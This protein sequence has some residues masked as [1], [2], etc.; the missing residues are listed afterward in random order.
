MTLGHTL[1]AIAVVM[2]TVGCAPPGPKLSALQTEALRQTMYVGPPV[3]ANISYLRAGDAKGTRV[4]LVH[5]TPGSALGWTD[6]LLDP[7]PGI[8]I[9]ALDRPGFGRS[10]PEHAVTNLAAQAAAVAALLPTDG[11]SVVL[12]GHSLG[13]AVVTRV[14]ADHPARVLALVLLATSLDPAQE[15]IHPAQ[16]V[17]QIW[18]LRVLLPR[19][20]RNSNDE[21]MVFKAQLEQLAPF[22]HQVKA[23]T[24]IVHGT[25]DTLVPVAN[26][27]YMQTHLTGLR[28]SKTVLLPDLDHFLPWNSPSIVREAIAWASAAPC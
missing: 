6:Y 20:L 8:E 28:C 25:R 11:R 23:A 27:H 18:P 12:L 3:N 9:I 5:G 1:S 22:L 2:T 14:A 15:K 19:A 10:E 17:A 4:I 24:V 21:L 16:H 13:G 7:P 26:V